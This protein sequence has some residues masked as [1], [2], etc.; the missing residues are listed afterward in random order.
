MGDEAPD[1]E[2]DLIS[3]PPLQSDLVGLC[4]RLNELGA[5]Y[6]VVGGYLFLA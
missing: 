2:D 4:R 3:R 1:P 6:V 5:K